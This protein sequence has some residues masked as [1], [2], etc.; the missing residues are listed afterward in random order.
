MM[1]NPLLEAFRNQGH[2]WSGPLVELLE[3]FERRLQLLGS[4]PPAATRADFGQVHA[5]DDS[6]PE[7]PGNGGDEDESGTESPS[8]DV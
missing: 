1:S 5:G 3:D 7:Q 6:E 2:G 4:D 8:G